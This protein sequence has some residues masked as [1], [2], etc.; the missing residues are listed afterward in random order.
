MSEDE[1][2]KR[3]KEGIDRATKMIADGEPIMSF[4]V[5]EPIKVLISPTGEL[6]L[7]FP[8]TTV[9]GYSS[10]AIARVVFEP[11]AAG[12]LKAILSESKSILDVPAQGRGKR[13]KQ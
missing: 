1:S 10:A 11:E 4:F 12:R 2:E 8:W 13:T 9:Q 3:R 5:A 6:A 7:D